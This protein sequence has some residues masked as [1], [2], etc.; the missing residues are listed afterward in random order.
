MYG[1]D[2]RVTAIRFILFVLT[3]HEIH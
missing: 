2:I 3:L 1:V